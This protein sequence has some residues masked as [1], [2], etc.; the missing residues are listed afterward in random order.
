[1]K[2]NKVKVTFLPQNETIEVEKGITLLEASAK[3][4]IY[5]SLYIL[6]Y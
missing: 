3:A 6:T 2:K 5:V 4:G 1:M